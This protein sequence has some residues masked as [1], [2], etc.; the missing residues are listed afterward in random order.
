MLFR[1]ARLKGQRDQN[2]S[3]VWMD[4]YKSNKYLLMANSIFVNN[5]LFL[6]RERDGQI[7][8][9]SKMDKHLHLLCY[10]RALGKNL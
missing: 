4:L 1:S 2:Q 6:W 5:V 9:Q 7:R 10:K 3:K 8:I